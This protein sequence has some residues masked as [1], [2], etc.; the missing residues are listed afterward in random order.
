MSQTLAEQTRQT[1]TQSHVAV[2]ALRL[3]RDKDSMDHDMLS[4]Q[5][6]PTKPHTSAWA[7]H[8]HPP[9][10]DDMLVDH[11][12]PA[13]SATT[14]KPQG[15]LRGQKK[16]KPTVQLNHRGDNAHFVKW[17]HRVGTNASSST[18][19]SNANL[20]PCTTQLHAKLDPAP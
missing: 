12:L 11:E 6:L 16:K 2:G 8:H 14:T 17:G 1:P 13:N 9:A 3:R 19:Q 18:R 15:R 20:D 10:P 4:D 7:R 5:A